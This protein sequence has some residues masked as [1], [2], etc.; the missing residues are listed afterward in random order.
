MI[1]GHISLLAV[2]VVV[3]NKEALYVGFVLMILS[4]YDG[5]KGGGNF[6]SSY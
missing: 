3:R 4:I 1:S 2:Y 6:I 5:R